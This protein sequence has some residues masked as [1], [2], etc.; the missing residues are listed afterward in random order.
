MCKQGC[1]I[2]DHMQNCEDVYHFCLGVA[3]IY[4]GFVPWSIDHMDI[5]LNYETFLCKA[6][7]LVTLPNFYISSKGGFAMHS[8]DRFYQY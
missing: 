8:S 1:N 3:S 5:H 7:M 2:W 4:A 6:D